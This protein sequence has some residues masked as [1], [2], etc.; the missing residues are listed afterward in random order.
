MIDDISSAVVD[1]GTWHIRTGYSG[2]DCPRSVIPSKVGIY[3][4]LEPQIAPVLPKPIEQGEDVQMMDSSS[5]EKK[6]GT[7]R[8]V[9][10]SELGYRRNEME[11]KPILSEEGQI[12]DFDSLEIALNKGLI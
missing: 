7:R 11:I 12:I 1:L 4:G 6:I 5:P 2:E 3:E 9:G 8:I 10:S